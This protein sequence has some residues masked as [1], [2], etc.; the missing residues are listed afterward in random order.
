MPLFTYALAA[1]IERSAAAAI[2]KETIL[3]Y[4]GCSFVSYLFD[5]LDVQFSNASCNVSFPL[6]D[7]GSFPLSNLT[8]LLG[9]KLVEGR[10]TCE[11]STAIRE[12]F[13]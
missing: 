12:L 10:E 4:Y 6:V 8:V 13:T 1:P 3:F 7:L 2:L 9:F 11:T 5:G